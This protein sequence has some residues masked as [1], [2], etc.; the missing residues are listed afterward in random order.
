MEQRIFSDPAIP[1]GFEAL[2]KPFKI[3]PQK[4]IESGQ[5]E[6]L[7]EGDG[8]DKALQ[9]IYADKKILSFIRALK[10]YRSSIFAMKGGR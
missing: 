10:T 8:I 3:S 4:N 5:V 6:F 7:V 1:A 9:E 2:E